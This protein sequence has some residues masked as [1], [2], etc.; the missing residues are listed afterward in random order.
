METISI[1]GIE[2]NK[3]VARNMSRIIGPK[4]FKYKNVNAIVVINSP[5]HAYIKFIE[6]S[7]SE[8]SRPL[9]QI[10]IF[11]EDYALTGSIATGSVYYKPKGF[12]ID[13][14]RIYRWLR[15]TIKEY[16]KDIN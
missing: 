12:A 14:F 11:K 15:K 1:T 10:N 13:K 8:Y 7:D 5:D 3:D 4:I 2:V 9:C 6:I 16:Q